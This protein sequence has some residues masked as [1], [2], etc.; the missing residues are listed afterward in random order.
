MRLILHIGTHKTGTSALQQ[1]LHQSEHTL[2]KSGIYYA[3]TAPS[4]TSNALARLV[5]ERRRGEAE[6][7][8]QRHLASARAAGADTVVLSA[9]SLY[10]MTMFF[11]KL[12]GKAPSYWA[13]EAECVELLQ[14]IL[15][16]QIPTKLVVF[17]RRQDHFLE[18][19]YQQAVKTTRSLEMSI[20]EFRAVFAEA[21]DYWRH[22]EIWANRFPDCSVYAYEAV[23]GSI[24]EFFLRSVLRFENTRDFEGLEARLNVRWS[25]DLLEYKKILNKMHTS[26][27]ERRMNSFACH[28]LAKALMDDGKYRDY[29]APDARVALL[30]QLGRGNT[31]LSEKFGMK[32]FPALGNDDLQSWAPYPGLS[33][34]KAKELATRHAHMK[35]S[36]AYLL[37]VWSQVAREVFDQRLPKL[38]WMVS[39]GRALLPQYRRQKYASRLAAAT[40]WL[41]TPR[42]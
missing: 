3:R 1:C 8:L 27:V 10:A 4:K 11:Q 36:A 37:E 40:R 29:L 31:L 15:P 42:P 33:A 38:A 39:L 26:A 5:A 12:S 30:G 13:S 7:L 41:R 9:E 34:E 32:P 25:R 20:E 28:M 35:T 16:P 24:S 6:G 19:I 17:F 23:S 14:S 2:L 21:L 18:A 22:I